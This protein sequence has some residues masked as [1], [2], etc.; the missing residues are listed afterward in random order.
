MP[1]NNMNFGVDLLP[2]VTSSYSLGTSDKKW[3]NVYADHIYKN[4]TELGNYTH[5]S[6]DGDL[7]VP[8]TGTTHSGMYLR[9]GS[10]SGDI[11]WATPPVWYGTC[12][13]SAA[14]AVKDVTC[15]GFPIGTIPT[16]TVIFVN[17]SQ[18]NTA[19]VADLKLRVNSSND[20][21][22][23]PIKYLY[24]AD[25]PKN[26]PGVGYI[27]ANQTYVFHYDG[28][29]WVVRLTYNTNTNTL[30]RTYTGSANYEYPLL[31]QNS[32]AN[33]TSAW[34]EYT[35]SYKD[36]Y[37]V[38]PNSSTTRATI[39]LSTGHITVPGGITADITGSCTGSAGS[40]TWDNITSKPSTFPPTIGT[41][42]TSAAAGDHAHGN[43]TNGGCITTAITPEN[44]DYIIIGDNSVSGKIGKGPAFVSAIS[45]QNTSSKF[46]REDGTWSAPSYY[47]HPTGDGNEHVPENGTTNEGKFL[48]ATSSAG[49]Y[50]WASLPRAT[51][52]VAGIISVGTGLTAD[53][54]G[55]LSLN[56][57]TTS[58]IG[59]VSVGTGLS[60]NASGVLTLGTATTSVLGG[61]KIGTGLNINSGVVSVAYGTTSTTALRGDTA[62]DTVAQNVMDDNIEEYYAVLLSYSSNNSTAETNTVNKTN[63][64]VYNPNLTRLSVRG[65]GTEPSIFAYETTNSSKAFVRMGWGSGKQNHGV[66]SGGFS[67]TAS[68]FTTSGMWMIY[69]NSSGNVVV[70]GH[71]T[72]DLLTTGGNITGSI[73]GKKA[74]FVYQHTGM[75]KGTTSTSTYGLTCI[76]FQDKNSLETTERIGA[77]SAYV[78]SAATVTTRLIAYKYVASSTDSAY[79]AAAYYTTSNLARTYTNCRVYGAVWNDYAEYRKGDIVEG[80]YCV[81]ETPSGTLTKSTERLQPGCRVTSDTFGFAIGETEEYQTP[82][83]VSGRVLV[84][85]YRDRKEYPLGAALC[86]A[87][88]G[89]V[90]VMTR[91]EIRE[92]P[93]RII[94]IVSEIPNYEIWYGGHAGNKEEENDKPTEVP[95][96]GR[97][98]IYVR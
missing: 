61:I 57:A 71:S 14:T 76:T 19:A 82:I 31:A 28:T 36:Y 67:P 17:F 38:I 26:I 40:I 73:I 94:G 80:G 84:Y 1:N 5:P 4:G 47:T 35:S 87:P 6:N 18:T 49:Y 66:Y 70:N 25:D 78:S 29:N 48:Q 39:N 77:L 9:A 33:A 2:T 15:A 7:H 89:K 11:A 24:N 86:S 60:V 16:G 3:L 85:P 68:S 53:S 69:R 52:S 54:D 51:S 58:A 50:Q 27:R 32:A 59:G 56:Y 30:L 74:G 95:V 37:G 79:F 64:L 65:A 92:Y 10:T 93:E 96:N 81:T 45:S 21:D 46:L 41:S 8:A 43:L 83:A 75:T 91:E 63:K 88:D 90:D 72:D 97:I 55:I 13:T 22:K 23:K 34:T 42:S 20:N 12:T 44:N 98:W 62:V